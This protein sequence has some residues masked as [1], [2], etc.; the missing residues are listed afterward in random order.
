MRRSDQATRGSYQRGE[1]AKKRILDMAVEQFAERGYRA[2]SLADI[3]R[4]AGITQPGLLYHFPTK[5]ALL[6]AVLRERDER[7]LTEVPQGPALVGT[8][9]LDAWDRLAEVNSGRYGLV[10]LS[11]VLGAESS[12]GG[13]PA[14]EYF[15]D[16]FRF[17][18]ELLTGAFEAGVA[19][20]E[21]RGDLDCGM[22]ANQV[23]A[24]MEGLENQW[25][26][27]PEGFDLAGAFQDYSR[28]VRRAI[29]R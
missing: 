29:V 3:A 21:L 10:Q 28:G 7:T 26:H 9:I 24:M 12:G 20:G 13:H 18:R 5:Q 2:A 22:L 23:I 11:H 27:D 16:H 14:A 15:R 4:A 19:S 6:V 17:G 25:L 8:E 1:E